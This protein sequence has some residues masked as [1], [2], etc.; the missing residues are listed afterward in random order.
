M[1]SRDVVFL[2]EKC[3]YICILSVLEIVLLAE[4]CNEV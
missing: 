1:D 2:R 3:E 4:G